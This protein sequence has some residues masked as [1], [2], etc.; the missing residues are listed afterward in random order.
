MACHTPNAIFQ[1]F[2]VVVVRQWRDGLVA[3]I[4]V[5]TNTQY[6]QYDL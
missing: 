1:L 3:I 5:V 6:T 2:V 4:P